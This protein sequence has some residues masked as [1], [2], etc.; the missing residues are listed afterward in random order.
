MNPK[1]T[2]VILNWNR[3]HDTVEC[4][5]SLYQIDYDSYNVILVDNASNDGSLAEID[6]YC[7][8]Y[9]KLEPRS[10]KCV[11]RD[12]PTTI[13]HYTQKRAEGS[14][15][16]QREGASAQVRLG[17]TLIANERN[18]GFSEG[19]NIAVAY[20]QQ[21]A[22]P[23]YILLLNNDTV[24]DRRF[25]RELIAVAE[26]D[27]RCGLLQPKMLHYS[28]L[29]IDNTGIMCDIF[30]STQRRGSYEK[31]EGKYD[32]HREDGFFYAS[33]ACVLIKKSVF[34]ALSGEC[35]DPHLFAYGEDLDLSWGARLIGFSVAYCPTS[36]CYHKVGSTLGRQ[37]PYGGYLVA[38]NRLRVP[39]KN[40]G[41]PTLFFVL[42]LTISL[43][44]FMAFFSCISN[45]TLVHLRNVIKALLWNVIN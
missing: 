22:N 31:D 29:T 23:D 5:E 41:F 9:R 39:I 21:T 15:D 32:G 16:N 7:T 4:L 34:S 17:L 2:I 45:F 19:N 38:R 28:D 44:L 24:V 40:Y 8:T 12:K 30:T 6:A 14:D 10:S 18:Y 37:S 35:F 27:E 3:S 33:G 13:V 11:I 42:P 20:A 1:V 26:Q 25:L 43:M 36:V